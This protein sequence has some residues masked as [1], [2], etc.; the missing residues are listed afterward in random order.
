MNTPNNRETFGAA[1]VDQCGRC[2]VIGMIPAS[3]DT[4]A[5]GCP[6]CQRMQSSVFEEIKRV[7]AELLPLSRVKFD[8]HASVFNTIN[9]V[10]DEVQSSGEKFPPF[11]SAHEGFAVLLEEVDELKAHVWMNQ[12]KRDLGAMRKEAI[13]VAAMAIRFALNVCDE[14]RGRK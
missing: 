1:R 3:V 7:F 13:Q 14:E 8:K 9:E 4:S 6:A 12:K 10:I 2:G 11:N 5:D